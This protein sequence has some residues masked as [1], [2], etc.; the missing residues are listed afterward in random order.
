MPCRCLISI[1]L[2]R[3][4]RSIFGALRYMDTYTCRSRVPVWARVGD[5]AAG[6]PRYRYTE[7][8]EPS[9]LG[10]RQSGLGNFSPLGP[11]FVC[12]AVVLVA[13]PLFLRAGGFREQVGQ[14][15]ARFRGWRSEHVPVFV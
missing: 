5:T 11:P 10:D 12:T 4:V 1:P 7:R 3:C 9:I 6:G 2:P 13:V 8:V 14:F 15:C